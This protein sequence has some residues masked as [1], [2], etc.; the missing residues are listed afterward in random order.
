MLLCTVFRQ[1]FDSAVTKSCIELT[2]DA[3][4][5][6]RRMKAAFGVITA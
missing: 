2:V 1:L 5:D 6:S 4:K 3:S